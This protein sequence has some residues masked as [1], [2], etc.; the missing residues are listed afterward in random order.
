MIGS[1]DGGLNI[2]VD[3]G[4]SWYRPAIPLGQFYH[5]SVDS[6]V[7]FHVAGALQDIGTAQGPSNSL[8]NGGIR[9]TDWYGV[10]GGE[11]GHV[12]S[13][14][15]DPNVVYAGE[16]GGYISR[17]DHR[18]KQARNVG[19]YPEDPSGH[20]GEDMRYRFQWTAPISV[21][22]HNPKVIYH[23]GNVLFR[24]EDSGPR[25]VR[26]SRATTSRNRN[27]RAV[28]SPATTPASRLT[29]RSSRSPSRPWRKA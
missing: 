20:G 13:D 29:A 6:R 23:G 24:T 17:Y 4:E 7:P 3:G 22:P 9:N 19:V 15:L 27:G 2:S 18:T 12:V 16:Y 26:T 8:R 25:S 1:D 14:P 21:S 10:G 5:V 28:R 11:A